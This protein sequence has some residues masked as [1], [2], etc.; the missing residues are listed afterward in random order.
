M[1]IGVFKLNIWGVSDRLGLIY[2][3]M[4]TAVMPVK[5]YMNY[6]STVMFI[7]K[8][9]TL[10]VSTAIAISATAAT[11]PP[12]TWAQASEGLIEEVVVTG[13]R[14]SRN[15]ESYLGSMSIAS[16]EDIEKIG[17]HNTLDL[18]Q[19]MPS[20]GTRGTTATTPMGAGCQF[21]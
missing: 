17:R 9:M 7:K 12:L 20:I 11:A 16:G 13:S 2:M 14:I 21:C 18:L 19:K 6:G 1:N 5:L 4:A 15:P 8:R 10:A 3:V